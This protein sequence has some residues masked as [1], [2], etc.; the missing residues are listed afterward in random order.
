MKAKHFFLLAILSAFVVISSC[1]KDEDPEPSPSADF[2][3]SK[4]T[5]VV[6]EE[7]QFT[8]TSQNATSFVWSFG[9]GNSS[10]EPSPKHTYSTSNLFVVTLS[11]TGSGGTELF[12]KNVRVLPYTAFTVV[13][14]TN[15]TNNT[16]VQFT[17]DAKGATTYEWSF[18]DP[19]NST[20]TEEDATFTYA[21]GGTYTVTLK[22]NGPGG[23]NT[24]SKSITVT[25]TAAIKELYFIEYGN[26]LIRKLALDGSA[27]TSDVLDITGKGGAGLAYDPATGKV[28]FSDFEVV[29]EGKIWRMNSDGSGLEAIVTGLT[30]P[31]GIA[32]DTDAGKIYWVDDIGNVSRANLDGTSQEIGIVNITDGLMRAIALDLDNDKMYFYE[33]NFENLYMANLDGSNPV[34]VV[35][36]V[37]G[38]GILVDAVN[39]KLYFEDQNSA[40]LIRANLDGS[41]QEVIDA[42]GTRMYGMAIDYTDN[43]LYWSG[44]DSG[45]LTRANLDGTS[46]EVLLTD[47]VSPRGIF[48]K[49]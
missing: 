44:R 19:A 29:P 3:V 8:N 41:G 26:S 13:N 4:D 36:G 15:L 21:A 37:Y 33:V 45:L 25:Q 43:K 48:I 11:A 31:Y 22:A 34:V 42:N 28:Y 17:N 10:T 24:A 16:P 2:T 39:D 23:Q 46:P 49:Q 40:T 38:Y 18:G 6:D 27:A 35:S 12:T 5:A 7:L 30:D 14:E 9:D 32:L 47:L 1:K 20:S